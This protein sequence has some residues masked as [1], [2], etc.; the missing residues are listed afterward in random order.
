MK[1][2]FSML[3]CAA[4]VFTFSFGAYAKFTFYGDVT[5]DNKINSSDA[6]YVLMTSVGLKSL[7]A[8][9]KRAADVDGNGKVNSSDALFILNFSIGK[10]NV[11]PADSDYCDPDRGHDIY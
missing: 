3:L 1:K 10:I 11:F 8:D 7:D 4:A 9:G 5:C 2:I 6:L